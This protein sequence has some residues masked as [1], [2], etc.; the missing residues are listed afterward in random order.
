VPIL[1]LDRDGVLNERPLEGRYIEDAESLEVLPGVGAALAAVRAAVPAVRIVVVTNQRGI[2][3]GLMRE[4]DLGAIHA[5]LRSDL[6]QAG[7]SLDRIEF[8]PHDRQSCGCRKPATGM[9]ERVLH[10]W[11]DIAH[12]PR[13]MVGDSAIDIVA[14]H[15]VGARTFLVGDPA[16]R[17]REAA[18][19]AAS[20]ATV[21]EQA[22]SLAALVMDGGL[23]AW[24]RGEGLTPRSTAR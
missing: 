3:L 4:R 11:P 21:D 15:R 10:D 24:L 13:A 23:V 6:E 22:D 18:S 1:F 14:G 2:A 9:F 5:R 7:A 17:E 16:R 19:A 8:C 20:G 12:G